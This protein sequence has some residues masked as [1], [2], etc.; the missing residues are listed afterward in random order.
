MFVFCVRNART[1]PLRCRPVVERARASVLVMQ[2]EPGPGGVSAAPVG[3]GAVRA[4]EAALQ[5]PHKAL[6]RHAGA[7]PA[8]DQHVLA[9]PAPRAHLH[10]HAHLPGQPPQLRHHL[11][12]RMARTGEGRTIETPLLRPPP[13]NPLRCF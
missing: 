5:L 13:F 7:R 12:L 2:E 9:H 6:P 3:G 8:A 4:G 11:A 1:G 10:A